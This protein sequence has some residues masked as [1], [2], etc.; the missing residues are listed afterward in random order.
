MRIV[1][2]TNVLVSGVVFGGACRSIITLVS[3]GQVCGFTSAA[4]LSE[5]EDVLARPK[6]GLTPQQLAAM[7]ELVRQTFLSVTPMEPT[8][9]V[10]E[11]PDDD[12]VLDAAIAANADVVVSGDDHLRALG[13]FRGIRIVSPADFMKQLKK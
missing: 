9:A 5:L 4:L 8:H 12:A 10:A 2:D 1:C 7:M 6:F 3:E 11:D 13:T